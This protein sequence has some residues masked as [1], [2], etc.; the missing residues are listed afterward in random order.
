MDFKFPNKNGTGIKNLMNHVSDECV[1]FI[2]KLLAYDPE[3]RIT[4]E[5]ALNDPYFHD[6]KIL[7]KKKLSILN[8][9]N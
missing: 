8:L 9:E 4:S 3:D 6:L 1:Q 5:Q 2:S 7:D